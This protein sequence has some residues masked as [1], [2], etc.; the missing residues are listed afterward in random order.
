MLQLRSALR[1]AFA[2]LTPAMTRSSQT[3][4]SV[5][6][7]SEPA[8]EEA[9]HED[10]ECAFQTK[11]G[12]ILSLK[13]EDR[14]KLWCADHNL[15]IE[16][17]RKMAKAGVGSLLVFDGNQLERGEANPTSA[18]SCMGI[19]TERDYLTKVVVQGKNSHCTKVSEIMTPAQ[20]LRVLTPSH[21]VIEAMEVMVQHNVRHVPVMDS[22]AMVGV[23]SMKDV[24]KVLLDDQKQEINQ[25]K[26]YI[27]GSY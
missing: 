22:N 13:E 8:Y 12:E 26:D 1:P 3:T 6:K 17:V 9:H 25:L 10:D 21:T 7:A 2:S 18:S 11:I 4:S 15:V 14:S 23:L 20:K 19:I 24:V 5:W 27:H 16:A